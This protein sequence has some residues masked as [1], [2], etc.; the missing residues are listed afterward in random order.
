MVKSR[1]EHAASRLSDEALLMVA[2]WRGYAIVAARARRGV[3]G[4]AARVATNLFAISAA[5]TVTTAGRLVPSH[6]V[7]VAL[8]WSFLP[9]LQ[10]LVVGFVSRRTKARLAVLD[11]VALHMAGNGPYLLFLLS[12]AA[13]VLV[14]PDV[15]GAFGWLMSSRVL[16]ALGVLTIAAAAVTSFAFYRVCGGESRR[17]ALGLLGV[18]WLAKIALLVAWYALIDNLAPQFLGPRGVGP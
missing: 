17:R 18:E 3:L 8:A 5:V 4:V 10:A 16:P 11:A 6:L 2:P 9:V 7:L 13:V 14:A 1:L 12:L 15:A